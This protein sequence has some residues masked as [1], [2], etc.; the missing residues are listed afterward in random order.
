MNLTVPTPAVGWLLQERDSLI[1]R[2]P[3]QTALALAIVHHLAIGNNVPLNRVSSFFAAIC[4]QLIIEFVP[5]SDVQVQRLLQGREDVFHDYDQ[6]G[7]EHAFR[8]NFEI[9][10]AHELETGGRVIYRL[11]NRT[12]PGGHRAGH[13]MMGEA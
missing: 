9:Q 10:Q 2:G 13:F 3:C 11:K 4:H 6:A 12:S 1:D 5:K 8:A 7:F